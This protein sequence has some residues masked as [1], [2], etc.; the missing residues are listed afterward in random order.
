M[1]KD[2]CDPDGGIHTMVWCYRCLGNSDFVNSDTKWPDP[3]TLDFS[4]NYPIHT[5]FQQMQKFLDK[6]DQNKSG[7]ILQENTFKTCIFLKK[8]YF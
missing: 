1:S 3:K 5:A 6:N 4:D 7:D 8:S 2:L